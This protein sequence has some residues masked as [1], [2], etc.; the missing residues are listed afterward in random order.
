MTT[1][2]NL[3]TEPEVVTR[4]AMHYLF[5]EKT[6][7]IPANAPGAWQAA[8]KLAP[9]AAAV[10]QI[11]GAAALYK[12]GPDVYRAGYILASRPSGV[13]EGLSYEEIPGGKYTRFVLTGSYTQLPE[14]TGRAFQ[15]VAEKQIQ[16]R[17]GFNIENYVTDPR[18]T[19]QEQ[20]VT[21][22]LFPAA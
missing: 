13:P 10:G 4:P 14:A 22:I 17:D 11:M 9:A 3:T 16:L 2:V 7:N 15:I 6:G 12:C 8:E 1:T 21:E 20:C 19:P 5:L 18:T